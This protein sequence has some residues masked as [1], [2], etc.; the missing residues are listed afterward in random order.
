[1][2]N[3]GGG[4]AKREA[5]ED[6]AWRATMERVEHGRLVDEE[7]K[8][9]AWERVVEELAEADARRRTIVS[10]TGAGPMKT[11]QILVDTWCLMLILVASWGWRDPSASD[12]TQ[13]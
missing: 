13:C 8:L 10:A 2:G 4:A 1:M 9:A 3:E 5:G 6:G 11:H 7:V 12:I